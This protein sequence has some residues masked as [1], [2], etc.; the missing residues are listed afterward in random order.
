MDINLFKS[1]YVIIKFSF[2]Y[3]Y[4]LWNILYAYTLMENLNILFN[5][6]NMISILII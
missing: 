3:L 6:Y 5:V 2:S 1:G 4:T